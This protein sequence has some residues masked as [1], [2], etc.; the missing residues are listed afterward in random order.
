MPMTKMMLKE[1]KFS[2]MMVITGDVGFIYVVHRAQKYSHNPDKLVLLSPKHPYTKLVLKSFHDINHRGVAYT[3]ARSRLRY[4]IPQA[5]KIMKGIKKNCVQ[6]A[7][8]QGYGA[9]HVATACTKNQASSS[10]VLLHA[11]SGWPSYCEGVPEPENF[12]EN[13]DGDYHLLGK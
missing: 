10:M 8:S 3:V 9:D 13:V 6:V 2:N 11:G 12:K 4:W 1:M 5:T 7:V